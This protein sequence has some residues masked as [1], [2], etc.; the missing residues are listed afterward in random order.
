MPRYVTP[1]RGAALLGLGLA[2]VACY[3]DVTVNRTPATAENSVVA[4]YAALGNSIT[5]G[6]QA[7]GIS[8]TTQ[9]QSYAYYFAQQAQTRFA[10]PLLVNPG[11]PPPYTNFMTQAR[12]T[13]TSATTCLLRGNSPAV[14]NNVAVPGAT[15]FDPT[16]ETTPFSN[17][18]TTLILGGR[19]QVERAL[20]VDPTFVTAWIGNND[21]LPA[22]QGS[23][24]AIAAV[25]PAATF[26]TNFDAMV[27][28]LAAGAENLEGGAFFGVVDVTNV[29]QLFSATQL[30]DPV[31]QAKINAAA[32]TTVTIHPNC[33]AGAGTQSLINLNIVRAIRGQQHPPVIACV[34]DTPIT[35]PNVGTVNIGDALVVD[36]AEQATLSALVA[37]YNTHIKAKATELGLMY[38]DPNILLAGLRQAGAVPA[39]PDPTVANPFGAYMSPDGVHPGRLAHLTIANVLIDSTNVHYGTNI[40]KLTVQ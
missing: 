31:V 7:G 20:Q 25:T 24:A 21:V 1:R 17:T 30:A 32:G 11:C 5:A 36:A 15:S 26:N 34:K 22:I 14:I 10:I 39:F 12:P 8:E 19:T 9:R 6:Y 16:A 23:T 18:L 33:L 40:P 38:I 2:V 35:I 3:P 4:R 29:P 37:G 28:G 13:G 27:D